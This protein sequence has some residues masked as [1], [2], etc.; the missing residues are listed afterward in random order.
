MAISSA[1]VLYAVIWFLCLFV[2]LPLNVTTQSDSGKISAGTAPSAPVN[3]QLKVK[4]RWA[5]FIAAI[6]WL[7]AT[8][9]IWSGIFSIEDIDVF[10]LWG[11]GRYG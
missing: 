9:L 6:I 1:L 4:V 3:P 2:L 11:D 10:G 8:G 7:P 5:T